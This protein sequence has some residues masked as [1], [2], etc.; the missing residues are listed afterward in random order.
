MAVSDKP[1][2][3][4]LSLPVKKKWIFFTKKTDLKTDMPPIGTVLLWRKIKKHNNHSAVVTDRKEISGYNQADV[5]EG[6]G[7][8]FSRRPPEELREG[9]NTCETIAEETIVK[10]AARL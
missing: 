8:G 10:K 3:K 4:M 9:F 1:T 7:M 6:A 2:E 5:L